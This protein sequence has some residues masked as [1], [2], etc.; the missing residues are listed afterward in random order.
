MEQMENKDRDQWIEAGLTCL[1]LHG[2]EGVRVEPLAK[3]LGVTKGSFYW[4]FRNRED[5]HNAML[6]EWAASAT[7]AVIERSE[8]AGTDSKAR[9]ERLLL[10]AAEGFEGKVELG[11]RN[12]A[13]GDSRVAEA[14][15]GVDRK[16]MSYLRRLLCESGFTPVEAEAR[17]FLVYSMLLGDYF[18]PDAH[19]RFS[20]KRVLRECFELLQSS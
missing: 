10:I 18:L 12:W 6:E 9:L 17:G 13:Q 11:L 16:R 3:Q 20:R 14:V 15:E 8:S 19:G 5:L 4:H 2:I 7:D 1:G